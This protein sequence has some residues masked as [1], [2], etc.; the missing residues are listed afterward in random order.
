MPGAEPLLRAVDVRQVFVKREG[1]FRRRETVAVDGVS[2]DLVPR[3]T[4]ALVGESGSGKTSLAMIL[5]GLRRPTSGDVLLEG[6]SLSQMRGRDQ[7]ALRRRMQVVFQ[8]PYG[9]LQPRMTVGEALLEVL[10]VHR[11]GSGREEQTDRMAEQLR[12]VGLSPDAMRRYPHE[13]S[14]GQRQ[15]IAIARSL[16]VEP[17]LLILDE[18]TSA[19]DMS[20][21]SQVLNLLGELQAARELTYFLITHNLDVVG[22]LADQVLVMERGQ[23]VERGSVEQVMD[24]P[25]SEATARL[26]ASLPSVDPT[27]RRL[28]AV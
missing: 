3:T 20:V 1:L 12:Q 2:F 16:I 13:F 23:I 11:I 10:Q 21:Q 27:C 25:Q 15:R 28:D 7:L 24:A 6:R 14:G 19:L 4:T 8:D 9:S 18:P 5:L 22:Y 17:S 26:L